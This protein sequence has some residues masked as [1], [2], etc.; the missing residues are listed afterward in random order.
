M[1]NKEEIKRLR[2]I[3]KVKVYEINKEFYQSLDESIRN[4]ITFNE[5]N[6]SQ[7]IRTNRFIEIMEDINKIYNLSNKIDIFTNAIQLLDLDGDLFVDKLI[8]YDYFKDCQQKEI[9]I[10]K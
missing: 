10:E 5:Y 2:E 1:R 7:Y 9:K 4:L 3:N 8:K 6:R